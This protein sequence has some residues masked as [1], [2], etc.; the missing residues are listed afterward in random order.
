MRLSGFVVVSLLFIF[1]SVSVLCQHS[2][3]A[4]GYSGGV[5]AGG[6]SGG[7]FSGVSG[8]SSSGSSHSGGGSSASSSGA[9]HSSSYAPSSGRTQG[10][11]TGSNT[12][13]TNDRVWVPNAKPEKH[14][15]FGFLHHK[16]PEQRTAVFVPPIHC[17]KGQNCGVCRKTGTCVV[18]TS[19]ANGLVWNGFS[20]NSQ[21]AWWNDCARI[22]NQLAATRRQMHG[23]N[24]PGLSLIYSM[25]L[26]QYQSCLARYG[27]GPFLADTSLFGLP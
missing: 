4:G 20:C 16:K 13:R 19:C 11:K 23:Q 9:S 25:L 6:Y 17:K 18:E 3:G 5:S 2:S 1:L 10:E 15:L 24:D 7:G 14:G 21:Y 8:V 22:A 12:V 26:R 27:E